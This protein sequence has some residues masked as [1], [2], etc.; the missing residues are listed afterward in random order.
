MRI[1][2]TLFLYILVIC[3][4]TYCSAQDGGMY[5]EYYSDGSVKSTIKLVNGKGEG[6][7]TDYYPNGKRKSV[8]NYRNG[9][10][11]GETIQY[12]SLE[13]IEHSGTYGVS[14]AG[15]C[16]SESGKEVPYYKFISEAVPSNDLSIP[17]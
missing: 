13:R 9:L 8:I 11:S 14:V 15:K 17:A 6:P 10:M 5:T 1:P 12:D 16:F 2:K 3:E 7:W 4:S